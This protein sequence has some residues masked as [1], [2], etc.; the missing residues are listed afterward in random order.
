MNELAKQTNIQTYKQTYKQTD[1]TV[2]ITMHT[3]NFFVESIQY[4][5]NLS[6]FDNEKRE[7][8]TLLLEIFVS[9]FIQKGQLSWKICKL[10]A[11]GT[12]TGMN[13]NKVSICLSAE[14][15]EDS[16]IKRCKELCLNLEK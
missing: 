9:V 8:T 10:Q 16:R 1:F 6:K 14:N 4:N 11:T 12:N 3:E 15:R 5:K 2:N 7:A 13:W